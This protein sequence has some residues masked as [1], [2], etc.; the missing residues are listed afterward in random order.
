[1]DATFSCAPHPFYQCLI[2]K[3]YDHSTSSY[4][5]ILYMLMSHKTEALHAF[6]QLV[7]LSNW[8]IDVHMYCSDFEAALIKDLNFAFKGYGG[9]HVG[10]FYHLKQC[11]RKFLLKQCELSKEI[12]KEA[13][14]PG[15]LDLLC[16]IPRKEVETKV[17]RFLRKK[18]EKGKRKLTKKECDGYDRFWKYFIKQWLPI[19]DKWNICAKDGDYY[20]MVNRT[21]N[22]LE[23]YNR[24]V[25]QLFPS[26]PTLIAF[27]QVI[28]KESRHQAQLLSN[29][30]TGKVAEPSR[31]HVQTIPTI[32]AEYDAFI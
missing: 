30:R 7:V 29:I 5:P 16:V 32:P 25:N 8:K 12:T 31:K 3:I 19:V 22:G 18:L 6:S 1:M 11:W 17:L 13:M 4:M 26:R 20:D 28:E 15:N 23:S 21:N 27:V 24:R 2:I 10:C 9:I 14:L